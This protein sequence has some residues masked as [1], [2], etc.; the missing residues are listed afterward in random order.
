[1]RAR[2]FVIL[3][4]SG[5]LSHSGRAE[6][7]PSEASCRALYLKRISALAVQTDEAAAPGIRARK[8]E[9]ESEPT[10]KQAVAHCRSNLTVRQVECGLDPDSCE[11]QVP[12]KTEP[13][14]EPALPGKDDPAPARDNPPAT[15]EECK[16]VYEHLLAVY[17]TDELQ[18]KPGGEELLKNWRSPVA[19]QSFQ[20][21]CEKVFHKQDS[22]CI[23]SSADPDIARACLLVIPE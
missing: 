1:M 13:V 2:I 9:L 14:T 22:E 7:K 3:L 4:I 11:E 19:R 20:A 5:F 10:V 8:K 17:A 6:D 16:K 23:L 12:E 18:K 21:R 15:A